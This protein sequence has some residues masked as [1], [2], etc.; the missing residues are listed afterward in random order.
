MQLWK[1]NFIFVFFLI[2]VILSVSLLTFVSYSFHQSLKE[3][4]RE[5]KNELEQAKSLAEGLAE[6]SSTKIMQNFAESAIEQKQSYLEVIKGDVLIFPFVPE[7]I[8]VNQKTAW[9]E[10]K[11]NKINGKKMLTFFGGIPYQGE[12]LKFFYAKDISEIYQKQNNRIFY[13]I[14]FGL[15]LSSF[16]SLIIYWQMKKIYKPIQNL[17]HELRTPLTLISGYSEYLMRMKTTEED[18]VTMNQEIYT[19]ALH[20]QEVVEQL[21][22]MGDLKEGKTNQ[23][24]FKIS[25]LL[26]SIKINY[27]EFS[28]F[29]E[30]ENIVS[31]NKVLILRLLI[32]L[33][34][35]AF[36]ASKEVS[37]CIIQKQITILNKPAT[38]SGNQLKKMNRG[39]KLS[40]AEYEGTGQGFAICREIMLLHQGKIEILSADNEVKVILVFK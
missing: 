17:S 37:I 14:L 6:N 7:D 32:N 18:Q 2:Q 20:L 39:R 8:M 13:S 38:I 11:L 19:E 25:E 23:E 21:L 4:V 33:L 10:I 29:I 27:P 5:F 34:D 40:P 16:L 1:K 3:E 30:K 9:N 22:I 12:P 31:G 35:N 15:I 26:S 28:I 36:R 24:Q